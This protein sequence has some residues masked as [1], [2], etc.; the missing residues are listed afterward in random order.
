[1][2]NISNFT[3]KALLVLEMFKFLCF[4]HQPLFSP[5]SQLVNRGSIN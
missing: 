3:K 4:P 1:M 5:V 2:G